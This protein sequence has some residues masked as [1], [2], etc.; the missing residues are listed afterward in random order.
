MHSL[1]GTL[2]FG[3]RPLGNERRQD[4]ARMHCTDCCE[5]CVIDLLRRPEAGLS[6]SGACLVFFFCAS[7]DAEDVK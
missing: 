3:I 4:I 5:A 2:Q 6:I 7:I 1:Q